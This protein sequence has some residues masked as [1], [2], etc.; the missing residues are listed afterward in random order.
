M[1][2]STTSTQIE[3]GFPDLRYTPTILA[4]HVGLFILLDAIKMCW[5]RFNPMRRLDK[6]YFV[7]CFSFEQ[8][9]LLSVP[10][11]NSWQN[12]VNRIIVT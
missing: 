8:I 11:I 4:K 10:R 9:N 6:A 12:H 3:F 1:L 7:M 5:F 2:I